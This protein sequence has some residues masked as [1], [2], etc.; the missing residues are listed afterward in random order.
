M[1]GSKDDDEADAVRNRKMTN[2]LKKKNQSIGAPLRKSGAS[3]YLE[4]AEKE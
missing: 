3:F 4:F 1:T 2:K